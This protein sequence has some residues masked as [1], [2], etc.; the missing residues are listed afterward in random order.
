[1]INP[2]KDIILFESPYLE[3]FTKTPWYAIPIAWVPVI[4][5]QFTQ[6]ELGIIQT[7]ILI[8]LGIWGWT[9]IEYILHRFLF[10]GEDY[11]LPSNK[12]AYVTHF[13]LHGIHHA[14]P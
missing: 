12:P 7:L 14:F 9:L 11:W 2:V 10:H 13:I 4:V 3:I 1:M 6:S 8:A 5:Y